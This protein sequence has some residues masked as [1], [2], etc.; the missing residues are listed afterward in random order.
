[1]VRLHLKPQIH[2]TDLLISL[3]NAMKRTKLRE[4]SKVEKITQ[5][6]IF[7]TAVLC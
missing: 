1:M 5:R 3:G 4:Q 2:A 6:S 7:L